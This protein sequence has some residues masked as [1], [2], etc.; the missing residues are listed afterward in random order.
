MAISPPSRVNALAPP[1]PAIQSVGGD[2][3]TLGSWQFST[4]AKPNGGYMVM[5]SPPNTTDYEIYQHAPRLMDALSTIDRLK[6]L[7]GAQ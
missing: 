3:G 1:D 2:Y 5:A 6:L 7:Y 4:R